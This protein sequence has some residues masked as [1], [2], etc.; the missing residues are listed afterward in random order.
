MYF[1]YFSLLVNI[2]FYVSESRGC[3]LATGGH[4]DA[5]YLLIILQK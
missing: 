1:M 4:S 3:G 2:Y 5:K